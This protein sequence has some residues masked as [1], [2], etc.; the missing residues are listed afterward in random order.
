MCVTSDRPTLRVTDVAM[1]YRKI[2]VPLDGSALA[3]RALHYAETMARSQGAQVVLMRAVEAHVLPGR[4]TPGAQ[5]HV[6]D[7]ADAYLS[8]WAERIA[9]ASGLDVETAVYYGT[10]ERGIVEEVTL[11]GADLVVMSTHG[12]S[13]LG[14]F[15]MGSVADHVLRNAPVPVMLVPAGCHHTWELPSSPEAGQASSAAAST[16]GAAAPRPFRMLVPLDGSR[17]AAEA[18]DALPRVAGPAETRVTL[19]SA[20][21]LVPSLVYAAGM[22]NQMR[23]LESEAFAAR[24]YLEGE[25]SWPRVLASQ[26]DVE[27]ALGPAAQS[28]A[29]C[30]RERNVDLVVM[31]THGRGGLSRIV[32]GSVATGLLHLLHCPLLLVRPVGVRELSEPA[33]QRPHLV[34]A[35]S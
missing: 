21:E 18:I 34:A 1:K 13:G 23:D 7:E 6:V 17:F 11:R 16:G 15:I 14:R 24:A 30:A 25:A 35:G 20:L 8:R 9:A 32:L 22:E 33:R 28:I 31:A 2:L 10:A 26:V 29:E 3:E 4:D 27:V 5:R 19:V 12:R